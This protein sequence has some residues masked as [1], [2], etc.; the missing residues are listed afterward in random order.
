[1]SGTRKNV[2]ISFV[3]LHYNTIKET[4]DCVESIEKLIDTEN[5]C[6]VIVDNCSPNNTGVELVN[7]YKNS[8]KI[9]VLLSKENVGFARGNNLGIDYARNELNSKYVCCTN[10]DTLMIQK[11]FYH[12]I[13]KEYKFS[14]AAVIGPRVYLKDNSIQQQCGELKDITVYKKSLYDL[15]MNK[16]VK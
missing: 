10:N 9:D 5:Y 14:N 13:E 16:K 4:V 2:D 6:I 12:S 7:K 1:M 15:E 8:D 3:I 11:N